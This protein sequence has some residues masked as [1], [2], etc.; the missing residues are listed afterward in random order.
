MKKQ[1]RDPLER[2]YAHGYKAAV[3]GKSLEIC[4]HNAESMRFQWTSGWREGR[5]NRWQGLTGV[6]GI[7]TGFI[8]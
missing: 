6:A 2:A 7:H 4:P 3:T 8:R 1:K 5:T